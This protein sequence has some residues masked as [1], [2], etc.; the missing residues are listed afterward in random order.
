M[1]NSSRKFETF[2]EKK[3]A[4]DNLTTR[5]YNKRALYDNSRP[6]K[7]PIF[8]SN[9]KGSYHITYVPYNLS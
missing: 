4:L 9:F 5:E 8:F 3:L 1:G 6:I 7:L 2:L